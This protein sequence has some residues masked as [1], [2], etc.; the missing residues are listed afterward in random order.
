MRRE[1]RCPEVSKQCLGGP[2]HGAKDH[3]SDLQRGYRWIVH[4]LP[5]RAVLSEAVVEAVLIAVHVPT[6]VHLVLAVA[7]HL[8]VLRASQRR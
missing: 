4:H 5:A 8:I 7:A 3:R 2:S 6:V 1:R